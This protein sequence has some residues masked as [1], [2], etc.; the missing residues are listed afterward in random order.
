MHSLPLQ[1]ERR[2][3]GEILMNIVPN[4][5]VSDTSGDDKSYIAGNM[6]NTLF[7]S[8]LLLYASFK[9]SYALFYF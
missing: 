1:M 7:S 8:L 5:Q 2:P 4:V 6:H 9:I 3:G